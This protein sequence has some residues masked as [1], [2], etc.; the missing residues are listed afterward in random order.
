MLKLFT[1]EQLLKL[2]K[3]L[4]ITKL[5]CKFCKLYKIEIS[6]NAHFNQLSKLRKKIWPP[7]NQL[8][9]LT[10]KKL[11]SKGFILNDNSGT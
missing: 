1:P 2:S 7:F 11:A 10:H 9:K 4:L 8:S 6:F 3:K 5:I